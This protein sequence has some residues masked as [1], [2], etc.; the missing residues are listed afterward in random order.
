MLSS[1]SSSPAKQ[2]NDTKYRTNK[3]KRPLTP[4]PPLP[5][6]APQ[7][8]ISGRKSRNGSMNWESI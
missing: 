4:Y 3:Y 7:N 1:S 8:R 2:Q 6:V 5:L